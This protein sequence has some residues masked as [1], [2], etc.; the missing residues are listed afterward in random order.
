MPPN[1][2]PST[3]WKRSVRESLL[4]APLRVVNLGLDTFADDLAAQDVLV[5]RL[6]WSPPREMD[7]KMASLLKKL[8]M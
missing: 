7:P 3:P 2:T 8:G 6:D 4:Q 5:A 1:P